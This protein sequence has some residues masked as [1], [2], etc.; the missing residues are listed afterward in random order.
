[1]RVLQTLQMSTIGGTL[2]TSTRPKDTRARARTSNTPNV[3]A[4]RHTAR[5]LVPRTPVLVRVLQ[6]LQVS[7]IGGTRARPLVPRTPALVRVLQT[8][9]AST[10]GG[11]LARV[12]VPLVPALARQPHE[13]Q[14]SQKRRARRHARPRLPPATRPRARASASSIETRRE[15]I[16]APSRR[17]QSRSQPPSQPSPRARH[18]VDIDRLD[19]DLNRRDRSTDRSVL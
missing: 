9:Q 13:F 19:G 5:P 17:Q 4:W 7:T 18:P 11:K 3:H 2:R 1:M 15:P 10:I 8:L 14:V 6:T 12:R 16:D